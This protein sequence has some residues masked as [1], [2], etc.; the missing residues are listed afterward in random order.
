MAITAIHGRDIVISVEDVPVGCATSGTLN[1]MGDLSEATCK[2]SSGWKEYTLG[3]QEGELT[4]EA[5]TRYATGDDVATNQT[6]KSFRQ[7]WKNRTLVDWEWTRGEVGDEIISGKGF[8]TNVSETAPGND[9]ATWSA[10]I[11][12]TG[13]IIIGTVPA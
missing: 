9:N 2:G 4:L 7:Y 8:I 13:E 3:D 5:L 11:K 12:P 1:L 10:T 6:V